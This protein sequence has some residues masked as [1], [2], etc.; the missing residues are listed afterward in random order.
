MTIT[1][2]TLCCLFSET[3]SK[4]ER[5]EGLPVTP[6]HVERQASANSTKSRRPASIRLQASA[7]EFDGQFKSVGKKWGKKREFSRK[8][9]NFLRKKTLAVP[10]GRA[11]AKIR[12]KRRPKAQFAVGLSSG[13]SKSS[14]TR[15][16]VKENSLRLLGEK[17]VNLHD[18]K[19]FA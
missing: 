7:D 8:F 5:A 2:S 17:K 14:K 9:K 13:K 16:C 11:R 6:S 18:Q 12:G 1:L 3:R 4:L 19:Y 10:E 15:K